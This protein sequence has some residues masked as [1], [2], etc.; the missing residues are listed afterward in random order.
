[1]Y[2][3]DFLKSISSVAWGFEVKAVTS[4]AKLKIRVNYAICVSFSECANGECWRIIASARR[5][6]WQ[7]DRDGPLKVWDF[8]SLGPLG[9]KTRFTFCIGSWQNSFQHLSNHINK[10]AYCANDKKW[11]DTTLDNLFRCSK[12]MNKTGINPNCEG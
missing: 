7:H 2:R 9:V 5:W 12:W 6:Q 1:M 10:L 11:S 8:P 3:A 4:T